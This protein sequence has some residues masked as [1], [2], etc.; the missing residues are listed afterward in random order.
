[1]LHG[2]QLLPCRACL[3]QLL[4]AIRSL[5]IVCNHVPSKKRL[6]AITRL[7]AKLGIIYTTRR[8][9]GVM[10]MKCYCRRKALTIETQRRERDGQVWQWK[11]FYNRSA[12]S[13]V[14]EKCN[15]KLFCTRCRSMLSVDTFTLSLKSTVKMAHLI[16]DFLFLTRSSGLAHARSS[17]FADL[18]RR[19]GSM[20]WTE[21]DQIFCAYG[22]L[23]R[24]ALLYALYNNTRVINGPSI[25]QSAVGYMPVFYQNNSRTLSLH[26]R[27]RMVA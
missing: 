16:R 6:I 12:F 25:H 17:F 20:L 21:T 2:I 23:P 1:M 26:M 5:L 22:F 3:D 14:I 4:I 8:H 24:D 27:R 15:V 11:E 19:I 10:S 18:Q 9:G 13:E 7:I